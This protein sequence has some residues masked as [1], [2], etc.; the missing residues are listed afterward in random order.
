MAPGPLSL[1]YRAGCALAIPMSGCAIPTQATLTYYISPTPWSCGGQELRIMGSSQV[2]CCNRRARRFGIGQPLTGSARRREQITQQ[3][4]PIAML[5]HPDR[6][7]KRKEK[8]QEPP[9]RLE[10]TERGSWVNINMR[11]PVAV[12][13]T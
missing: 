11:T 8:L 5:T 4:G 3:F 13:T 2:S 6:W 10:K 1:K 7:R 12:E 9:A